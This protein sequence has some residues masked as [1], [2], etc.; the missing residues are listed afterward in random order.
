[1]DIYLI[2]S[3]NKARKI[4]KP[5]VHNR[6]NL[7]VCGP[8]VYEKSHIG[9]LRSAV[10]FDL[11]YRLLKIFYRVKYVRNITDIDDKITISA[12]FNNLSEYSLSNKNIEYYR[13][14][15]K[16]LNCIDPDI[17]PRAT[18]HINDIISMIRLLLSREH[19][20]FSNKHVY[21]SIKTFK[22]YGL[23]S[24]YRKNNFYLGINTKHAEF[25]R[26]WMDFVLWKPKHNKLAFNSPWGMG[27]PGWHIECS[28][29]CKFYF[30]NYFDVHGGGRIY[31][32][33][34]MKMN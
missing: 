17:E 5:L 7:Y 32:F 24:E 16:V 33:L 10:T 25:K 6:V 19:A 3:L 23:L 28:S 26:N 20:Y 11:V 14:S 18:N 31:C 8:T 9:N 12:Q 22:N 21:F 4:F 30:S 1:M 29:I 34:T 2:N 15:L 13:T 27:R